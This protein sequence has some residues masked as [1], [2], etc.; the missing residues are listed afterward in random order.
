VKNTL[1]SYYQSSKVGFYLVRPFARIYQFFLHEKYLPKE[2]FI[3]KRF[4][5]SFGYKL[6]LQHPKTLNE[7][8]NWLK[9]HYWKPLNTVVADKYAVREYVA[10][11]LDKRYLV[12]MPFTTKNPEEVVPENLPNEPFII[13]TN[14]DSS[15]GVIIHDK[16]GDHK[17]EGIQN[18]LRANMSQNFFWDGREQ[19][20]RDIEPRII[21]EK[22]LTDEKGEL[23]AD[24]KLHCFNGKVRMINVDIG[25]GTKNKFRQ[26]FN[27]DWE[28]EPYQWSGIFK[29]DPEL[30][31]QKVPKPKI[32]DLMIKESEKLSKDFPYIRIDWYIV[33]NELFFGEMTFHHAGGLQPFDPPKWDLKLGEELVLPSNV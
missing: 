26:W 8:I 29:K 18:Y 23:P 14:H 13:K 28:L 22:L 19:Q 4:K 17:W 32:L 21:V 7:K 30:L 5:K 15:G 27:R 10:N 1:K 16:N 20:Y 31:G 11:T 25:K 3:K 2:V 33:K 6:D 24:Y 9:L 12:P